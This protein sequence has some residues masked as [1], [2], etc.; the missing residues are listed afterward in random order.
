MASLKLAS[1]FYPSDVGD[2][3]PFPFV[4]ANRPTVNAS[5]FF[6]CIS[7]RLS[8][9]VAAGGGAGFLTSLPV[10]ITIASLL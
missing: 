10:V 5:N 7:I 6:I 1:H 3:I 4:G 8:R 9:S 2:F